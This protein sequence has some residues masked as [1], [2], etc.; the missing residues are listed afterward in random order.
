M[1]PHP[2]NDPEGLAGLKR[3][4]FP[5]PGSQAVI[6]TAVMIH[7]QGDHASRYEEVLIPLRER[8]ITCL[9]SD[10]PGHGESPGRRGEVPGLAAVDAIVASDLDRAR[11]LCP[12]GPVGLVGHSVGGLLALR[13]LL[14]RPDAYQF[15]WISSPLIR[16][17]NAR[18]PIIVFLLRLLGKVLPGMRLSTGVSAAMCR[19]PDEQG[20]EP[21]GNP[22]S[23][24]QITLGWG[25]E[26]IEIARRVRREFPTGAP[27]LPLLFTQGSADP[28]CPAPLL[29]TLLQETK[30][31]ELRYE[32]FEG[33]LHEPFAGPGKEMVATAVGAWLDEV[34]AHGD[35]R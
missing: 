30:H 18:H 16:P 21:V 12:D 22:L 6:G 8:G 19:L 14:I 20:E 34:L 25:C 9:A 27:P 28:V 35:L 13:E 26:L 1:I 17:E 11:S 4:E 7:G 33:L 29:R 24:H 10:L 31:P 3:F 2:T 15:A 23:H 5:S 32:E